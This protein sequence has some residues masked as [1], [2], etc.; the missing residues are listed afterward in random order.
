[1]R[2]SYRCTTSATSGW[3]WLRRRR[4]T[5]SGRQAPRKQIWCQSTMVPRLGTGRSLSNSRDLD[6]N[7]SDPP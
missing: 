4:T 2:N 6:V 5:T 3:E 7:T 1:M